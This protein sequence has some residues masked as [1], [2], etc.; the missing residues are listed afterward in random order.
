M[1]DLD[2]HIK[3]SYDMTLSQDLQHAPNDRLGL[4]G[5]ESRRNHAT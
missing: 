5:A 3:Y 2:A 4:N 1:L